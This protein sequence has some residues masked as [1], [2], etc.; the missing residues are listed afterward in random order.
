[1]YT[2]CASFWAHAG[3]Q[4]WTKQWLKFDNSYFTTERDPALLRLE[5]D[6]AL[7]TDPKFA[8]HYKRYAQS[9]AAFFSDYADAHLRLSELGSVFKPAGGIKI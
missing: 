9:Q 3:G 8:P 5:T 6:S 2:F 1:M 7:E 4:S